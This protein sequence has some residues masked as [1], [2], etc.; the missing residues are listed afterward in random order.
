MFQ[1]LRFAARGLLRQPALATIAIVTLALAIGANTAIFTVVNAVLLRPLPYPEPERLVRIHTAFHSNDSTRYWLSRPEYM[2]LRRDSR[3]YSATA[4]WA[5]GTASFGQIDHP[6]RVAA[7]WTTAD[8]ATTVGVAP[9]L[10]RYFSPDEARPGADPQVAVLGHRL[11]RRAFDGDPDVVGRKVTLDG[12]PVTIVGVMPDGFEFPDPEVEAWVPMGLDPGDLSEGRASH[13]IN[14]VARLAPDVTLDAARAEL[15]ALSAS[16]SRLSSPE[17]HAVDG[18]EHPMSVYPLRDEVVGAAQTP[19]WLLQASVLFVLLI[20]CA[21]VSNLLLARAEARSREI[22]VRVALGAGRRRLMRLFLIESALLAITGGALGI[23]LAV[24]GVDLAAGLLPDGAPRKS[25]IDID[26]S[27][28]AFAVACAGAATA[29]FGLTPLW[30]ARSVDLNEDLRDGGRVSS[31]RSRLRQI[32]VTVEV[33]LAIVLVIGCSLALRSFTRLQRVDVGFEPDGLLTFQTEL[34]ATRYRDPAAA[35]GFWRRLAAE[36]ER[37]PGV[38]RVSQ[39]SGLPPVQ[40]LTTNVVWFEGA[41]HFSDTGAPIVDFWTFVGDGHIETLG[42]RL[43]AGRSLR[44]DDRAAV[45]VNQTLAREFFP[46]LDP[47]GRSI[48]L[49]P[50]R[51][52]VPRQTIVGV[53]AD[54]KQLGLA[55]PSG[56]EAYIPLAF[57]PQ[58]SSSGSAPLTMSVA[59]RASEPAALAG[60]IEAAVRRLDPSLPLSSVRTM[61]GLLWDAVARPRF[62]TWLMALFGG[63][64]L[65]L[66]VIGVYGVM[67]ISVERRTRELGIRMALGA[68]AEQV[69]RMVMRQGLLLVGS[70]IAAGMLVAV[71]LNTALARTLAG[72]LY[73]TP[74]LHAPTFAAVAALVGAAAALACW[75]PAWRATRVDPMVALRDE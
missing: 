61:D 7:A 19:L 2:E 57:A 75:V 55:A 37:L 70:G 69:Q 67:S 71:A 29:V 17:W 27:V 42:L 59:V 11:W 22:A 40:Q 58:L 43:M 1:D 45:V 10:G 65:L 21:N 20:A 15:A 33:A 16:W 49:A 39:A 5:A 48:Q 25:E 73:D 14:V 46:G 62:L 13:F 8:F 51:T 41:P 4:A 34:P 26:G 6:V 56:T 24:W 35:L 9:A 72:V 18:A 50:W 3:S 60:A 28:L 38:T 63:L 53:V 32:L 52:D 47:I 66:A 23:L 68:R 44:P 12:L 64:A 31:R 36:L 74:P 54:V 30:H